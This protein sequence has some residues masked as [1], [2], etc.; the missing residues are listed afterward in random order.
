MRARRNWEGG[1]K[2]EYLGE[3]KDGG[4]RV[5]VTGLQASY[6]EKL[7]TCEV[8]EKQASVKRP[9]VPTASRHHSKPEAADKAVT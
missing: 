7:N 4:T 2:A 6:A 8:G 9:G 5:N 1:R 3:K